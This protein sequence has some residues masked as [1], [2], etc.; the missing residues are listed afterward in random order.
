MDGQIKS[1][2]HVFHSVVSE[3][4]RRGLNQRR[5]D[6]T[7]VVDCDG[8]FGK[9]FIN[10]VVIIQKSSQL[11]IHPISYLK[12][13]IIKSLP[14]ILYISKQYHQKYLNYLKLYQ[15]GIYYLSSPPRRTKTSSYSVC[16]QHLLCCFMSVRGSSCSFFTPI[17]TVLDLLVQN[18]S[19]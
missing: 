10:Q 13:Y 9:V 3:S 19:G 12:L 11:H 7:K 5:R 14:L 16:F 2:L 17:W 6:W 8:F 18:G 4:Q 15:L 1:P